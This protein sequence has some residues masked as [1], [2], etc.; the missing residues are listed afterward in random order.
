MNGDGVEEL[1]LGG[2]DGKVQAIGADGQPLWTF[3]SRG[4]VNEVTVQ[5]VNGVPTVF[6][7]TENWYVHVLSASGTELWQKVIPNDPARREQKGNLIGVT[8]IRVAHVNGK[9]QDP[10]IMVGTQFRYLYG[11]DLSGSLKYEDIAYFYG[12]EDMEFL[13]LDGDGKDEGVLGLEYYYYSIWNEGTL[14]RYGGSKEPGPGFK[15]VEPLAKWSGSPQPA[16]I[17]G[18]K[19]NRVHMIQY[20][21][22]TPKELWKRNVGGEVNDIR[23]GGFDGDGAT[24]ILV[25]SDGFQIY[26]LNANGSIRWRKTVSDRVLKIAVQQTSDGVR[27]LAVLDNGGLVT[28]NAQGDIVSDAAFRKLVHNAHGTSA[29]AWIVTEDGEA[30]RKK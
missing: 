14:T 27:Y 26:M 12:I 5:T 22:S 4:R 9:Q 25:A 19:Q 30:Y 13:D 23:A 10:W 3:Q 7:A 28:L 17:Y 29:G 18:T 21:G 15:V 1:L 6:V 11:F 8:N 2:M 24:E 16:V 20:N